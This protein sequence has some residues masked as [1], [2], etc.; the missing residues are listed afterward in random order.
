MSMHAEPS[1]IVTFML[2]TGKLSM[3]WDALTLFWG[4]ALCGM[5][6]ETGNGVLDSWYVVLHTVIQ[7]QYPV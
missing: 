2:A 5:L 6:W 3:F 4:G 7:P 1:A